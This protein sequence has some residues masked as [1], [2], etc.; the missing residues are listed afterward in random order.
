MKGI[1]SSGISCIFWLLQFLCDVIIFRSWLLKAKVS[2]QNEAK[3]LFSTSVL[4]V[5][6]PLLIAISCTII[7]VFHI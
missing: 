2:W 5:E 6:M 1:H 7:Y 4:Q 3:S